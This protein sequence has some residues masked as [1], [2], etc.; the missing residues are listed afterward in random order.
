MGTSNSTK[1]P[2]TSRSTKTAVPTSA[3]VAAPTRVKGA[4]TAHTSVGAPSAAPAP[5]GATVASAT[6]GGAMS[7]TGHATTSLDIAKKVTGGEKAAAASAA[8][9]HGTPGLSV[10]SMVVYGL[11]MMVPV[12]PFAIYGNVFQASNGM[13]ALSYLVAMGA[14]LFTVLSFGVMIRK[15]PSSGSIFTYTSKGMSPAIGFVAGWLML[16]QYLITPDLMYLMGAQALNQYLP[17]V[18]VWAWCLMFLAFVTV[19]SL[20]GVGTTVIIDRIALAAQIIVIA[21]FIGFGIAYVIQHP[22]TASFA[23]TAILDP[24][25]FNFGDMMSSVS[26]CVLS[27][28][29]FGCIAT[30]TQQA[31]DEQR[32][33]SKAMMITV[34]TLGAMFIAMCYIATCVDPTGNTFSSNPNNGFY[35]IAAQ[36]GG[37]W[38]GVLCAVTNAIA[39]GLFAGLVGQISI[40]RVMYVM[41]TTGALPKF[42]DQI[43]TKRDVPVHSTLFVSALSLAVLFILI[44]IG[45]D[46]GAKISNFGALST[47]FLLNVC[48]VWYFWMKLKDHKNVLRHL[49][50]PAIGA[51]IVLAILFSLNTLAQVV[52]LIWIAAGIAY[53]EIGTRVL[54]RSM[55]ME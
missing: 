27:F 44:S 10:G 18:P 55:R 22:T 52:G 46:S 8:K 3:K 48:V 14:M 23:P 25:K 49:I 39:L 38:L 42:F 31:K 4:V 32:G 29:G 35:L 19:V 5:A 24:A 33:P 9:T 30:L 15:W 26:L 17:A 50:C 1:T 51:L 12:A 47:Y 45:V 21:L 41:G 37:E 43:N 40:A 34:L 11:I 16:L 13:P 53:Y 7:S 2:T 6:S 36:V 20:R 28:V 54:H